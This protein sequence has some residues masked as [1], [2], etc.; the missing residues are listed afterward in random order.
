MIVY[1]TDWYRCYE[2]LAN[3][4]DGEF[5]KDYIVESFI[6]K[7]MDVLKQI[8]VNHLAYSGGVDSTILLCLLTKIFDKVNTYTI[9]A[10]ST[11]KDIDFARFGSA[12]FDS[13]H[14][15]FIVQPTKVDTDKFIGDNAVRQLYENVSDFTDELICGDGIDE[16]MCGYHRHKDLEFGTYK[17][18]LSDLLDGHLIPLEFNS[19][20]VKVYLPYLN[21]GMID[22]YKRIPLNAKVDRE[23]RKKIISAVADKLGIPWTI[24]YRHKYGFADAF[25]L[26]EKSQ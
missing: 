1:P 21:G 7:L 3:D 11:H 9:A 26:E 16:F 20:S 25:L 6:E 2:E 24:I 4:F 22:L 23:N 15:E 18:F 13:N 10:V 19:G 12:F 8:N 5:N 17:Y 14:R